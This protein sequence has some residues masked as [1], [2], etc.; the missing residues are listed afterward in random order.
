[1]SNYVSFLNS[2]LLAGAAAL[3]SGQGAN[4]NNALNYTTRHE[5]ARPARSSYAKQ[6]DAWFSQLERTHGDY[7]PKGM[8]DL[9]TLNV[10]DDAMEILAHTVYTNVRTAMQKPKEEEHFEIVQHSLPDGSYVWKDQ[11]SGEELRATKTGN[12]YN[13]S[14]SHRLKFAVGGR[15]ELGTIMKMLEDDDPNHDYAAK[16][17]A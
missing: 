16:R 13:F 9:R 4:F 1:M 17:A 5:E 8:R 6:V 2:L 12:H 11:V 14:G 15:G 10:S 3:S 7:L